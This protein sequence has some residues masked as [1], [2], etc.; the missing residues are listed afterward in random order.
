MYC[1]IHRKPP[2][3]FISYLGSPDLRRDKIVLLKDSLCRYDW[4]L[5]PEFAAEFSHKNR[6]FQWIFPLP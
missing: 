3:I 1:D 4:N 2:P 5:V 6:C